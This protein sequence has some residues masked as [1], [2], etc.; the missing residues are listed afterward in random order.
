[1]PAQVLS[2]LPG[3]RPQDVERI[4]TDR[5]GSLG[6]HSVQDLIA[7]ADVPAD[8]AESLPEVLVFSSTTPPL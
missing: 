3:L 6:L 7:T 8:V 4:V 5:F 1:M 2:W